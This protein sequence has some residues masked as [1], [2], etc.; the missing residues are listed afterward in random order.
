MRTALRRCIVPSVYFG[1]MM[2]DVENPS[3]SWYVCFVLSHTFGVCVDWC[4]LSFGLK[5]IISW[6]LAVLLHFARIQEIIK[7]WIITKWS[8]T[9]RIQEIILFTTNYSPHQST[10]TPKICNKNKTNIPTAWWILYII[11]PK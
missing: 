11:R 2:Y 10:H 3:S 4:G 5:R 8:N 6:I 9:A 1:R 7:K